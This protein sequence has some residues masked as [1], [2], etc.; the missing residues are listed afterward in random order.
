MEDKKLMCV[1]C[2][3]EWIPNFKNRCEC[4]GFCTWG[5]ELGIPESFI[6]DKDGN[7]YLKKPQKSDLKI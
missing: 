6:I 5:Y 2:G 4:G 1:L 3:S 7:W